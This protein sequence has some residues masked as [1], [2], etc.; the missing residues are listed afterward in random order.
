MK[1]KSVSFLLESKEGDKREVPVLIRKKNIRSIRLQVTRDC[2]VVCTAS[3]WASDEKITGFI[4]SKAQWIL[5]ALDRTENF[6][7]NSENLKNDGQAFLS[8]LNRNDRV[9]KDRNFV[10][11]KKWKELAMANFEHTVCRFLP[12]FEAGLLPPFALKGRSMHS[13]W[14]NCNTKTKII[15]FSW[16]L[17]NYPQC[18]IDY[19]VLHEMTHFLYI[20]HDKKFYDYIKK[21]MPEYKD[22]V[23][24]MK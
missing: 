22:Y 8:G 3:L 14:G 17:F 20:R 11:S 19:V 5:K 24:M 15:T 9:L 12:F 1:E 4:E 13:M 21:V 23:R 10:Y 7:G 2:Q 18:C 16:E 6:A